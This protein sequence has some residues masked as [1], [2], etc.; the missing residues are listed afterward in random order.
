MPDH[1]NDFYENIIKSFLRIQLIEDKKRSGYPNFSD[2]VDLPVS[3]A[4]NV[5]M[6]SE[7]R[8]T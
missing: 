6:R 4:I 2:L 1:F 8:K 5:L 3:N 7:D